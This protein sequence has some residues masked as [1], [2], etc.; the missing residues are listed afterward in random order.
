MR[1]DERVVEDDVGGLKE[2]ER[3]D[4][5]EVGIAG[6][7]ADEIDLAKMVEHQS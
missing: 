1:A 6:A 3:F 7:S 5:E 2:A 4:G